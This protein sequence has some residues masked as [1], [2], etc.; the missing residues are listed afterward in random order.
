M[1]KLL[2]I[3]SKLISFVEKNELYVKP[4]VKL[5]LMLAAYLMVYFQI[6]YYQKVH[7][8]FIP[9]IL[10]V[11]CALLPFGACAAI[12]GGYVLINLYG[13]GIEVTAVALALMVLCYILYFRFAPKQSHMFVLTPVLWVMKIP[14]IGPTAAGLLW[15]PA[16]G[17][18]VIT[19]TVMYYFLSGVK[20]NEALFRASA[21]TKATSKFVV[22]L[23]QLLGNREMWIV[24]LAFFLTTLTVYII[25]RLSIRNAWKVAIYV[26]ITLQMLLILLGKLILGDTSGI[27]GLII[28]SIV[29][30]GIALI[31]EFFMF[32]LDYTRVERV[33]FEDDHYYYYVKAIPKTLLIQE[34]KKVTTFGNGKVEQQFV[35]KEESAKE[36]IA[37]ELEID[38]ELLK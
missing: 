11:I 37:K 38:P 25:R 29:S 2:E 33:Q 34:E 35:Q 20:Q 18:A 6:G 28:G 30:M 4:A 32:H 26:G 7:I 1:S 21:G 16:S 19:G 22:A 8:I 27:V 24:I 10:A 36:Q 5:V 31:I 17:V 13:L 23:N 12:L 3:K 14:Y 15:N 9:M